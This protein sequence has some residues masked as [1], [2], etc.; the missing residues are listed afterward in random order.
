MDVINA[1]LETMFL[2]YPQT[3]RLLEAKEDLRGMMEDAYNEAISAGRSNNEA[4]GKVIAEFGNIEELRAKHQGTVAGIAPMPSPDTT[5]P[6][7]AILPCPAAKE[8]G[9]KTGAIANEK[10]VTLA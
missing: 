2:P 1:Y 10:E 5:N 4:V 3:P 7:I 8:P 6:S 9:D